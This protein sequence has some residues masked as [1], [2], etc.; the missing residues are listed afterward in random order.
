MAPLFAS[1]IIN[2][3]LDVQLRLTDIVLMPGQYFLGWSIAS[4]FK[5]VSKKEVI[6]ILKQV[7][8]LLLLF[9]PIWGT[10]AVILDRFT[11]IDLTSI[12]LGLARRTGRDRPHRDGAQRQPRGCDGP[13]RAPVTHHHDDRPGCLRFDH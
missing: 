11:D 10:M 4:R 2:L 9:V 12:I 5:G 13:P 6:E 3:F 1:L 7:F 8:V